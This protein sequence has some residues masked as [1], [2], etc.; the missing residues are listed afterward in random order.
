MLVAQRR[1]RALSVSAPTTAQ[2][3][4]QATCPNPNWTPEVR[5]GTSIT[6]SSFTYTVTFAGFSSPAITITGNDP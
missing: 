6:L 2:V 4:A 5:S 3:L 1:A